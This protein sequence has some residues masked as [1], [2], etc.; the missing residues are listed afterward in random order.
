MWYLSPTS[1]HGST[2]YLDRQVQALFTYSTNDH[3]SIL[4]T[5]SIGRVAPLK[6]LCRPWTLAKGLWVRDIS[7]GVVVLKEGHGFWVRGIVREGL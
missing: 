4:R 7:L 1:Y 5:A 3:L 2:P 6:R